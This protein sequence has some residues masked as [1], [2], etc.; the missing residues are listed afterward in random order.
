[1]LPGVFAQLVGCRLPAALGDFGEVRG[2]LVTEA[3]DETNFAAMALLLIMLHV[4][5][6]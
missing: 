1:L 2:R 6:P 3:A 4:S 5:S